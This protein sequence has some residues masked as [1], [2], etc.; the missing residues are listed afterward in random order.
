MKKKDIGK[1]GLPEALK[2]ISTDINVKVF[3]E[4]EGKNPDDMKEIVTETFL[5]VQD[6]VP[7]MPGVKKEK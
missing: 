5:P 2:G 6:A 1:D 3:N 4:A 7:P